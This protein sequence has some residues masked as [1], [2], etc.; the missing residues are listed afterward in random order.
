[1]KPKLLGS[2]NVWTSLDFERCPF[3]SIKKVSEAIIEIKCSVM[4]QSVT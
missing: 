4:S 3:Y 1:M 2:L